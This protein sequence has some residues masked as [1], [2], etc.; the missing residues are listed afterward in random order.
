MAEWI[1]PMTIG[2][3]LDCIGAFLIAK[4]LL[5][6]NLRKTDKEMLELESLWSEIR[7]F[8]KNIEMLKQKMYEENLGE[9]TMQKIR[10][11]IFE[12]Y[13]ISSVDAVR[14]SNEFY[15][16][17]REFFGLGAEGL[18]QHIEQQME[19]SVK[20]TKKMEE[21]KNEEFR[22]KKVEFD[23]KIHNLNEYRDTVSKNNAKWGVGFLIFGFGL[24][25]LVNIIQWI[26]TM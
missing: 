16:V 5:A 2:L 18:A 12:K 8:P 22:K 15:S 24:V 11:R 1:I 14:F 10:T 26:G 4:P 17:L 25:I 6:L 13:G 7:D 20:E 3:L 19:K 21:E 23:M 9:K